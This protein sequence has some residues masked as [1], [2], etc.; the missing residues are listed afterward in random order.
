MRKT[1]AP[2]IVGLGLLCCGCGGPITLAART[3]VIEPIHDWARADNCIE[4]HRDYRLAE[5][6]WK[7]IAEADPSHAFSPDFAHG[8]R[9]GFADYVYAGGTGEPPPV[10]PRYYWKVGYE[11]PQGHQAIEDWFAGF[12]MGA[13]L[14][15]E[16]GYRELVIVPSSMLRAEAPGPCPSP[17]VPATTI[18]PA[19]EP[20]LPP[21]RKLVPAP[22][23]K[24]QGPESGRPAA[25]S[26]PTP[27]NGAAAQPPP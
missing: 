2:A 4:H 21:P 6:V 18:P 24:Q 8:F 19:S 13:E 1:L 16:S 14:A 25:A 15:R 22:D 26:P 27:V 10:P 17:S 12:R 9:D 3:V 11:T 23:V 20:T 7:A 5:D